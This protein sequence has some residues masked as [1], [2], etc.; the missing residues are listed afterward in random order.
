MGVGV[1]QVGEA[2]KE[3]SPSSQVQ[4]QSHPGVNQIASQRWHPLLG[5]ED[6]SLCRSG[7]SSVHH[8]LQNLS[9]S[10]QFG[11]GASLFCSTLSVLAP[12]PDPKTDGL[13]L[14]LIH[15]ILGVRH[16]LTYKDCEKK[17]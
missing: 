17:E 13:G 9:W 3:A 10:S 5:L 8:F 11:S 7:F 4:S 14:G 15:N 2:K 6:S 12:C 1:G 16:M